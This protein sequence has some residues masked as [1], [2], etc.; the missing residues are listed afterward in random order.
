MKRVPWREHVA[1]NPPCRYHS[2]TDMYGRIAEAAAVVTALVG[3]YIVATDTDWWFPNN[4]FWTEAA[5]FV[6]A[7]TTHMVLFWM[8]TRRHNRICV[9]REGQP[10]LV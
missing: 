7:W 4:L 8:W 6:S 1:T 2:A 5:I 10:W 3:I 9:L